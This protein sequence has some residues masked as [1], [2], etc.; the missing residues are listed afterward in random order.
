VDALSVQAN[1]D[2]LVFAA[3]HEK[4]HRLIAE[5][6]RCVPL[7]DAINKIYATA[8]TWLCATPPL[9]QVNSGTEHQNLMK[10]LVNER[11]AAAREAMRKHIRNTM[12]CALHRL[13]LFSV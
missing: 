4:L 3:L 7:S 8:A 1:G 10:V 6:A 5:F 2:R 13:E 12:E 9:P 11:P